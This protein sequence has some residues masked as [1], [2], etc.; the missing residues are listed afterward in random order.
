MC[1]KEDMA[2]KSKAILT[3]LVLVSLIFL[4]LGACSDT[5]EVEK[6][7]GTVSDVGLDQAQGSDLGTGLP[8]GYKP[9]P[10]SKPGLACNPH[11]P[12]A[13]NPVCGADNKCWP[14]FLQNCDD[15]LDCTVDR[16]MGQG[17]C[18]NQPKTGYCVVGIKTGV[19][20][21]GVPQSEFKCVTRGTKKPDDPCWACNPNDWDGGSTNNTK[22]MP[23][24][25]GSCDDQNTCTMNDTC[26]NGTCKGTYFGNKC[27]DGLGCTTDLCDGKG[28]CLGNKMKTDWCL[29]DKTC[30]KDKAKHPSGTC[31]KCDVSTNQYAWTPISNSCLINGKCY[32]KGDLH[33]G[34]CAECNPT[35]STT[36]WT[37]TGSACLIYDVCKKP[38]DKDTSGCSQCAPTSNKYGWTRISGLC[39]IFDKCY[40]KGAKHPQGCAECDPAVSSTSWTVT[41]SN[42]YIDGTCY[43]SGAKDA[44]NCSTCDPTK[45][46]YAWTAI[47]GLC[48]IS[49][50][51]YKANDKHPGGCAICDPKTSATSWTVNTTNCLINNLCKKPAEKDLSGCRTCD[52]TKNKYGW[53]PVSG[54]CSIDGKCY[55]N[56]TK[57]P[58][59]C[60]I[61]DTSKS[62]TA[63]T[64]AGTGC[65][66]DFKCYAKGATHSSGCGSCD[67]T[68]SQ[69]SWTVT[70]GKCLIHGKCYSK[71]TTEVG[72]CGTCE[73]TKSTSSWTM[74]SG[75]LAVHDW[76][77]KF[78]GS[79]SDY[80]Y[81][82]A[83][84]NNGN[85][86]ITGYFYSYIDFG[87]GT[88][89]SKGSYDIF[90]A[91]FTP[92]GTPRWSKAFGGTSSDY[93]FSVDTDAAGNVYLAGYFYNTVNFGGST[94]TSKGGPDIFLASFDST[95]KHRWSKGFGGTSSDLA[96]G[97]AAD[98]SGNVYITG[99]FYNTVLFG[100][101]T[102]LTSKGYYDIFL[103]AFD[104]NGKYRWA[105]GF[106]GT[107]TSSYDYGYGIATD[108]S[109]NV[110]ITGYTYGGLTFGGATLTGKGS[111]DIFLASFTPSG[112]HRWS[113][114]FGSSS[115]DYGYALATDASGNVYLTGMFYNSIN[116][117]G[118]TLS[119]K[120][121]NDTFIA[122]FTSA[123][124]H[125]WSKSFGGSQ[126][127]YGY[128]IDADD[129]GN[130]YF[131]GMFYGSVN[132]GGGTLTSKG[133]YDLFM[134]SYTS[135][136]AYRWAR[137]HGSTSSDYGRSIA[138]DAKGNV[139]GTGYFYYTVDFGGG[140]LTASS[141]DIYLVK[142][143]Q[144]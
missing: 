82:V 76:S 101:S 9:Y 125:R 12:C 8:P 143:K 57:H 30:Y 41:G 118:G 70:S 98:S 6:D 65:I 97:V 121:S 130:V 69:T 137:S 49:G 24:S 10:C 103:A 55:T 133:S 54:A 111:Y 13:V 113:K 117:G 134:A 128:G 63:W 4:G 120:G 71:G 26:I 22:W 7:N 90:V 144:Q 93:G 18:S 108:G 68:K 92:A 81:D 29:I 109:G 35:T 47:A 38:G 119:S 94:L 21:G 72:G 64:P 53:T 122:S 83:V 33:P 105:K 96:Y 127:E 104:T 36:A 44:I 135:S 25:G 129:K 43:K 91:S 79:S 75:C 37:V 34:K 27:A 132:F 87:G 99:Y 106:G 61:C 84:D 62:T 112:T 42:C 136:G 2:M 131:T 124:A 17:V 46:K 66:I 85:V 138:A 59:G 14:E 139:Y 73:P 126:Y 110:Y 100:G 48:K 1:L 60:G 142:L 114:L 56:G 58:S 15:K 5:G 51:C 40:A 50:S 28:G 141:T 31:Y 86:Y 140:P 107:G 95:G 88:L 102:S 32:D 115:S 67:P 23:I 52:T 77:K 20:D 19:D 11:D 74:G 16:C 116:F 123:G 3:A 45:A 89:Y 39:K 78:G 80:P